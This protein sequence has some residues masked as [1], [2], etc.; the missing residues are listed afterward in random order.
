MYITFKCLKCES[1]N[2]IQVQT[3]VGATASKKCGE[4]GYEGSVKMV[5]PKC[6]ATSMFVPAA[7]RYRECAKCRYKGAAEMFLF[8]L[9]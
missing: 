7:N 2:L 6:N 4:C 5:C 3:D 1:V 9:G 8:V